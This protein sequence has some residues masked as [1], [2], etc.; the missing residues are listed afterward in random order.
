MGN[1]KYAL[2]IFAVLA[3]ILILVA[4]FAGSKQLA[5]TGFT[6]LDNL[7]MT[8]QGRNIKTGNFAPYPGNAPNSGSGG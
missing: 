5:Q 6:G 1:V 3:A 8:F 4:Y 7:A 2:T